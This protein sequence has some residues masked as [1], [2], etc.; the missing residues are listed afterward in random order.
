[1][2][3]V[4]LPETTSTTATIMPQLAVVLVWTPLNCMLGR[5]A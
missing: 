3:A 4:A 5:R 1:M 2:P